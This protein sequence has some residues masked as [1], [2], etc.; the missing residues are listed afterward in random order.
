MLRSK[1]HNEYLTQKSEEA[2]LLLCKKQRN[3]CVFL[4]KKAKKE[5]MLFYMSNTFISNAT[6]KLAKNETKARQH[7]EAELLLF[8]NFT[9][10]IYA[11][12]Q[13]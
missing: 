10:F 1:L 8:E 2:R 3:V 5:Y 7:P 12:I 6:L 9:F 4:L 11:I 13:E